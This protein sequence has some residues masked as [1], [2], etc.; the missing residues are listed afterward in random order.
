MRLCAVVAPKEQDANTRQR[1]A[2][3]P[4]EQD[5]NTRQHSAVAPKEQDANTRQR[6]A[7]DPKEPSLPCAALVV[8]ASECPLDGSLHAC[9]AIR[10]CEASPGQAATKRLTPPGSVPRAW[11]A[12]GR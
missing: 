2:V 1:S 12:P 5:A 10:L 3:A 7:L 4:K 11:P 9:S 8:S 6:S